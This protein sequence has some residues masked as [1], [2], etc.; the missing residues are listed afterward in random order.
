MKLGKKEYKEDTRTVRMAR[1]LDLEIKPPKKFDFDKGRAPFP[2]RVW[3]NDAYGDCVFAAQMNELLRNERVETRRTVKAQ[4]QD[5]IRTYQML[6]GCRAPDDARDNGYVMLDGFNFWR[7][8]GW[9]V[10][11]RN[12]KIAA[13]GELNAHDHN[14]L[15]LGCYLLRGVQFGFALPRSAQAQTRNGYWDVAV[16]AGSEPGS[17][18]GHAVYGKKY[19]DGN[20]YVYSW[21]QEIRVT[22]DFIDKYADETWVIV[23]AL[24]PWRKHPALDVD[25]LVAYLHS[26]GATVSL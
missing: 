26:I 25:K 19:D 13:F 1:F 9:T 21:G 5:V 24:D 14:Q 23:D 11:T 10:D 18:G 2:V 15:R 20:F 3:G 7:H 12:Y 4:D 6:T 8:T 16:G 17:W 22:N